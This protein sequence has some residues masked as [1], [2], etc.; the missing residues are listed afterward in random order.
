MYYSG[1][2]VFMFFRPLPCVKVKVVSGVPVSAGLG[3]SASFAVS[4]AAALLVK[5]GHIPGGTAAQPQ[6]LQCPL[7]NIQ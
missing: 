7:P 5:A 6:L 4:L 3:S 2:Q 1:L